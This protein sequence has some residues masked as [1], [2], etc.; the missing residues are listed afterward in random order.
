MGLVQIPLYWSGKEAWWNIYTGEIDSMTYIPE[1]ARKPS[2]DG[3]Y[4][5]GHNGSWWVCKKDGTNK[6]YLKDKI[7]GGE[8]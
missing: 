2:C 6:W 7:T 1:N 4:F 3:E 5:I 8:Q